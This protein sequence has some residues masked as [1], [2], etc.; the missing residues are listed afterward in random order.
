VHFDE[1]GKGKLNG[2]KGLQVDVSFLYDKAPMTVAML[3]ATMQWTFYICMSN[4]QQRKIGFDCSA[5]GNVNR[6]LL[7]FFLFCF[8]SFSF[9]FLSSLS[10][11]GLTV[12]MWILNTLMSI[13]TNFTHSL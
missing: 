4:T 7:S 6:L 8:L 11:R 12:E 9:Y 3:R 13:R 5:I 2:R 1:I 10:R